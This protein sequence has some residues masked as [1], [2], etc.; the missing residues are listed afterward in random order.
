MLW[1]SKF[2]DSFRA[3]KKSPGPAFSEVGGWSQKD[4]LEEVPPALNHGGFQVIPR[5]SYLMTGMERFSIN[6]WWMNALIWKTSKPF[7]QGGQRNLL[8]PNHDDPPQWTGELLCKKSANHSFFIW[9]CIMILVHP[10]V[11]PK[12]IFKGVCVSCPHWNW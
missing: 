10:N 9:K 5:V 7:L 8:S 2:Q 3:Q 1:S 12:L 4:F 6:D 11:L